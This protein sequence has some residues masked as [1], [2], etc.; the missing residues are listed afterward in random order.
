MGTGIILSFA[1][2]Q[3]T[4]GCTENLSKDKV[5]N[6]FFVYLIYICVFY[7]FLF[8]PTAVKKKK[9]EKSSFYK[10]KLGVFGNEVK[11][12]LRSILWYN[13]Y[14]SIFKEKNSLLYFVFG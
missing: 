7:E 3:R 4:K 12:S 5:I 14:E 10:K 9:S 8:V 13:I 1:T 2:Q 6:K 11:N